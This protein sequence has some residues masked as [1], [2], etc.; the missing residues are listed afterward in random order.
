[1]RLQVKH[2]AITS[3]M[4]L[5][6]IPLL[7][8]QVSVAPLPWPKTRF[9]STAGIPLSGGKVCTY[10]A[11]GSTPLATYPDSTGGTPNANPVV[12]DSAGEANIWL[13]PSAYKLVLRAADG[14]DGTCTTGSVQWTVDGLKSPTG[15]ITLA[16]L[17][18][19]GNVSIAG[20]LTVTGNTSL[21]CTQTLNKI[22]VAHCFA[23][24]DAGAKIAAAIADLPSTGGTVDARGLE[25]AQTISQNIFSGV[26]K[27]GRLII[28]AATVTVSTSFTLPSNWT[29]EFEPG[30]S[31]AI[32]TGI[33]I[34]LNGQVAATLSQ[35]FSYTGTGVAVFGSVLRTPEI[36]PQW[37]GATGDGTTDDSAAIQNAVNAAS[38]YVVNP[39]YSYVAHLKFPS[40]RYKFGSTVTV[41]AGTRVF[42]EGEHAAG[43]GGTQFLQGGDTVT[44]LQVNADTFKIHNIWFRGTASV[45]TGNLLSLGSA[46]E[47]VHDTYITDCWFA[48]AAN[49]A[50]AFVNVSGIIIQGNTLEGGAYG[51]YAAPTGS[52][53]CQDIKIIGNRFYSIPTNAI[54]V[55]GSGSPSTTP[56][57]Y[58]LISSNIFDFNGGIGATEAIYGSANADYFEIV[59][60]HFNNQASGDISFASSLGP[61]IASNYSSKTGTRFFLGVDVQ[62]ALIENN[63]GN[64]AGQ[65]QAGLDIITFQRSTGT[66]AKN[67]VIGNHFFTV[68]TPQPT[69]GLATDAA[70]TLT[71]AWGNRFEN[72]TTNAYNV[73]G[74]LNTADF[75]SP[76]GGRRFSTGRATPLVAG[77]FSLSGGWGN[78]AAVSAVIGA[79]QGFQFVVTSTGT[80][81]G[82][83]PTIVITD[84]DGTWTNSPIVIVHRSAGSQ[85]TIIDTWT[86]TA[87]ALT[88]TF[89]G[90]PVAAE[91]FTY[92][93]IKMGR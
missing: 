38:G 79:D 60:N 17:T 81:Q 48:T 29:L 6:I 91:T 5:F 4:T 89:V 63:Q 35:I 75:I 39:T 1:M 41:A 47:T 87:T 46:T 24:A 44:V 40:G 74:T 67:T 93:V 18:V 80:G 71:E 65:G 12:L 55:I 43:V 70:T 11:G 16:G 23:G 32:A 22:Q 56:T 78:T 62:Y 27:P 77:D 49:A 19:T 50:I 34:T 30:G 72:E 51:I 2:V 83:S 3:I 25:G 14:I 57:K 53:E 92:N 20:T 10:G 64:D 68:G 42:I 54:R 61:H 21:A 86:V 8:A 7:W 13:G 26:T 58:W 33:T 31:F 37:W 36:Y 45:G 90:T 73:L 84:K 59:G 69:F 28:G 82:A 66:S 15:T 76:L 88:I 9:F 85:P 52:A